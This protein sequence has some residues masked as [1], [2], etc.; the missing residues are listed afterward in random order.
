[1]RNI[2]LTLISIF[3]VTLS[4]SQ[5][6]VTSLD[7]EYTIDFDNTVSGVNNG[8][9]NGSGFNT[10]PSTGQLDGNAW[11][12]YGF[13][14]GG[15]PVT[16][17]FDG[18]STAYDHIGGTHGGGTSHARLYAFTVGGASDVAFGVNPTAGEFTPG[19]FK[20]KVSYGLSRVNL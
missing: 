5:L 6:S 4:Y 20:L 3:C 18:S 9:Y 14:A 13:A 1:M 15:S 16:Q 8:Q 12:V 2:L 7:T 17:N 10:S 19:Y 11:M